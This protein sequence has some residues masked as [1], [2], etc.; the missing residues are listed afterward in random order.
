MEKVHRADSPLGLSL[1]R[2]NWRSTVPGLA[3]LVGLV[4]FV[5]PAFAHAIE[6]WV[7]DEEF[8]YGFLIPPIALGMV[9][10]R[11]DALRRS[12]D[13]GRTAGLGIA[14]V[15]IVLTL[16]SRRTEINALSGVAVTP[17]LIGAA[18]YLWGWR[19][20][21]V[22]LF[23]ATFLIF[24]LGLYRGLLSSLGFA[25]QDVTAGGAALASRLIGLDVVRD[26]LVLHAASD[27]PRY[28]FVV[29]QA[30]SGMN[31]LLS[32]L[33]LA[34]VLLFVTAGPLTG[35]AAVIAGVLPLVIVANIA[36]VTLV[37]LI[38]STFGE[39]TALGF[40]H[41]AS[42]LVLFGVALAGMLVLSRMVGCKLP[43]FATS[44]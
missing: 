27:P 32:L 42:S 44:A 11:R 15:A 8:S 2:L 36:R 22:V 43:T 24:G 1:S 6:V 31:S 14:V 23:P 5:W 41:G 7:T 19:A 37:L 30:C 20:G 35:R 17:L 18:V 10:W 40:F 21:R 4:I 9:W 12:I 29:A 39:D 34:A 28:A 26:G 25:L 13:H 38:A 16:V 3:L 33:A